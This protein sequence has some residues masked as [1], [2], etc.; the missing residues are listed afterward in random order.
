ML[1][2]LKQLQL[3]SDL[4]K[5]KVSN[6]FEYLYMYQVETIIEQMLMDNKQI[7]NIQ[8]LSGISNT[9]TV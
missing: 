8:L 5:K 4:K 7:L 9:E 2:I 3:S 6:L 1:I